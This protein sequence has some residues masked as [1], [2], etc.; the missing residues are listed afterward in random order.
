MLSGRQH[1]CATRTVGAGVRASYTCATRVRVW[2]RAPCTR[3]VH[4]DTR[5]STVER[6][7]LTVGDLNLNVMQIRYSATVLLHVWGSENR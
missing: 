4:V 6:R 3:E 5:V 2:S 7:A 1:T